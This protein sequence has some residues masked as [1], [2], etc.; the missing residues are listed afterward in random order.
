[1]RRI[2]QL[3]GIGA[4][5]TVMAV[6]AA[7]LGESQPAAHGEVRV[8]DVAHAKQTGAIRLTTYNIENLFD[9][10]DDLSLSGKEDDWYDKDKGVRA[11]PASQR[12]G[13]AKA[14]TAIDSDVI[15]VEEIESFDALVE[16]REQYL[17]GLGYD[18]VMSID[19]GAD[20]GIQQGVLSRFPIREARVW[21][22]LPLGGVHP[23]NYGTG[24][25]WNA[26]E[27]MVF[28]RSPLYVRIEVPAGARG[29]EQAY[30]LN[31]FVVHH[32]S[33]KYNDYWR[34]KETPAVVAMVREVESRDPKANIAVL[35]DFN[36]EATEAAVVVYD[37]AGLTHADTSG[38]ADPKRTS[39]SS[40]RTIDFILVNANLR[41]EIVPDSAF[42]F[43]TPVLPEEADWRTT[44]PPADFASDHM[45]ISVD[46]TP[47]DK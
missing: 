1:M 4:A 8:G 16:F 10:R 37:S 7:C 23:E 26:G 6:A 38:S 40:G 17:K 41:A 36:A 28:R 33:G 35:G 39:H 32:K 43:G 25:N 22:S 19:S 27:P 2:H 44:P 14:I 34:E 5:C 31:L 45:P 46:I 11:K 9:D 42:A 47:V 21:P 3:F 13:V 29:N 20:R 15:A 12:E 18:Y 24:K 30:E